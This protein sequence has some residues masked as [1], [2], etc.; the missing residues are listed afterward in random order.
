MHELL[1]RA[2]D[3]GRIPLR[4]Y[5]ESLVAGLDELGA[6]GPRVRIDTEVDDVSLSVE[7]GVPCGLILNELISNALK[8]GFPGERSGSVHVSVRRGPGSELRLAVSDDGV[9]LPV[10]FDPERTAALGLTIA[11]LL[12]RQLK[13]E[14]ELSS[15]ASGTTFQVRFPADDP[16]LR[17][18]ARALYRAGELPASGAA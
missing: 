16:V 18:D 13:G 8:H 14:L 7:S 6:H 2:H 9:G 10:G 17:S 1:Y 15:T 4:E 3:A 11:R 5:V 12:A